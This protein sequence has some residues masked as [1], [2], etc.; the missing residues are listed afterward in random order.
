[1]NCLRSLPTEELALLN[2]QVQ[3]VTYPGPGAGYGVYYFGP[4]VDGHFIQELPNVAF[5]RGRFYDVPL[6]VDREE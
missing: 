5:S 6:I 1:M 2:Q 4:V 3:N